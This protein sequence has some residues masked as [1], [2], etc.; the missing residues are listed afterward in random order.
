MLTELFSMTSDTKFLSAFKTMFIDVSIPKSICNLASAFTTVLCTS[1]TS[2]IIPAGIPL[3]NTWIGSS[4]NSCN[5][6]VTLELVEFSL[7]FVFNFFIILNKKGS[8]N[9]SMLSLFSIN[10]LLIMSILSKSKPI[11]FAKS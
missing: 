8:P 5:N 3:W 7:S 1:T 9:F 4:L 6:F 2:P 11:A 10:F